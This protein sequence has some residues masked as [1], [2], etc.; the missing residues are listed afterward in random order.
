MAVVACV[1]AVSGCTAHRP[2]GHDVDV[3]DL[4][5][6][7]G[8]LT[9]AVGDTITWVNHDIVPHTVTRTGGGWDSGI[10]SQGARY[11]VVVDSARA[12]RYHC[13]FHPTMTGEIVVR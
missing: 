9:V 3:R 12:L 4:A 8:T 11:A 2:S 5:F 6:V 10:V 7:P 1:A 13:R